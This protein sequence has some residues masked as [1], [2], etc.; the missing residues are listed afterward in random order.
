MT[1]TARATTRRAPANR[2]VALARAAS[3][4][5]IFAG[6]T[7]RSE[8][9][10]LTYGQF[11]LLDAIT[12]LLNITGPAAIDMSTW[13]AGGADIT[14]AKSFLSDGR[15]TR[16]R[17]LVDRSFPTRQPGYCQELVRLFGDDAIRTTQTHAKF[18]TITAPGWS[19][20]VN[21][22]MNMN[23]NRRMEY[24]QAA[25]DPVLHA[26][27]VA[28]VDDVFTELPPGAISQTRDM[29]TLPSLLDLTPATT[30]TMGRVTI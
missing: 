1:T 3:A 13:T 14:H 27:L 4:R 16:L 9:H 22:S 18:A 2:T 28:V 6:F 7:H 24:I 10:C 29:P 30:L 26:F 23:T 8:I 21:T 12:A 17:F 19:V 11:S 5:T 20:A 15:I 25:D